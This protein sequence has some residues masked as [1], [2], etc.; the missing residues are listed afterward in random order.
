MNLSFLLPSR[1]LLAV[2]VSVSV[3]VAPSAVGCSVCGCSLSSDWGLQ[4]YGETP[5]AQFSLRY[6][7]FDQTDL[8]SGTDSINRASLT[9]PNDNEI[10][11]STTNRNAWLG[12]DYVFDAKWAV[13]LQLPYHDRDHATIA[14]GDTA[15]S[16]SR[17]S[18]LGDTR[19]IGRY[20]LLQ[21]ADDNVALQFGLKLP[22]GR[23]DQ[24]FTTG[25]QAGSPVDRGLQLGTGTTD[26][27]LGVAWFAR[28][29]DNLGVFAQ[30][31]LNQP[32]A[33]RAGFRP[34]PSMTLNS[35]VRWLNT[36]AF[37]P[38]LQL[39][40]RWDGREHGVNADRDNSGGLVAYLS[41]GLTADLNEKVNAFAFVQL[42]VYQRVTGLQLEPRRLLSVGLRFKL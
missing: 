16:T 32:L 33:Q 3:A 27:L 19:V 12:L 38:Q 5:G 18:G 24:N 42:P 41:P 13:A 4:G 2:F 35:G 8:R 20:A 34:S 17:A 10:Q 28:P 40:I 15:V 39:N 7:Y 26:L 30:A 21:G 9:F 1:R 22:T 23:F 31:L 36:S 29:A 14:A 11:Q 25:P 37:T 6:E